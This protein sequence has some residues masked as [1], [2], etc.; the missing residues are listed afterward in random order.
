MQELKKIKVDDPDFVCFTSPHPQFPN[1]TSPPSR[2]KITRNY[3]TL[4]PEL[5]ELCTKF[6]KKYPFTEIPLRYDDP[7][8]LTEDVIKQIHS[9]YPKELLDS[10]NVKQSKKAVA[11]SNLPEMLRKSASNGKMWKDLE[12]NLEDAFNSFIDVKARGIGGPGEADVECQYAKKEIFAADGKATGK[13]LMALAN[14]GLL[15]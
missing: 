12:K 13:K 5:N 14:K 10:I 1:S 3:I 9:F 7:K 4:N 11:V 15:W 6:L 8:R 2:R